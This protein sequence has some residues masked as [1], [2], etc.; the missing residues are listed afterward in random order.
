MTSTSR[1]DPNA[2]ANA[3]ELG[4]E[5]YRTELTAFCYRMLGSAFEAEDAVQETLVRAWRSFDSVRGARR[6]AVVAVSHREQRVLRH[7]EGPAPAR[8]ADRPHGG[9]PR[10]TARRPAARPRTCG[11]ARS[12][13]R[14]CARL[15]DDPAEEAVAARV[16]AARVRRRAAAPAAPPARGADPAR[17]LEVEGERGRRAARHHRRVA[18]TARSSERARRSPT[19]NVT[20]HTTSE[21]I[22][23]AQ[24][25]LLARYVD[26][27]ER[28]DIDALVSLL[29]EDATMMM[30]PY[31]L[32]MQ[33]AG[34]YGKW[35]RGRAERCAGSRLRPDR[36]QRRPGVRAVARR[37]RRRLHGL[38]DP[39]AD[40]SGGQI[41]A[42]DFF[43]DPS[44]FPLF[45]L[46]VHLDA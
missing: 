34:E 28:F 26:T 20:A 1:L 3:A 33:G 42:I 19:S 17:S 15:A 12:R 44:L 39:P 21:P 4:F 14:A 23:D 43:V 35:L 25:E 22:D 27:F 5:Q 10:A 32:W 30:P 41:T 7:V 46:P 37:S 24:H 6:A 11:S 40:V 36:R 9:R 8:D 31:P 38:V 45:D 18:S 2:E 29:H 16:G 13:T